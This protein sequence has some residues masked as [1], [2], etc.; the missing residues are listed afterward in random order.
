MAP[1]TLRDF[2]AANW[3]QTAKSKVSISKCST[4]KGWPENFDP[5]VPISECSALKGLGIQGPHKGHRESQ[6]VC[7]KK[8]SKFFQQTRPNGFA[9]RNFQKFF[10]QTRSTQ[11]ATFAGTTKWP[12]HKQFLSTRRGRASGLGCQESMM[13]HQNL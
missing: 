3:T 9:G 11:P 10:Q 1:R 7:Q 6:R 4:L 2:L 5:Q 13:R 12:K 8:L